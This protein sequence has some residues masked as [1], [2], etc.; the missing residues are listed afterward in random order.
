MGEG[1][2]LLVVKIRGGKE[3]PSKIGAIFTVRSEVCTL[4]RTRNCAPHI[5]LAPVRSC[6]VWPQAYSPFQVYTPG[7]SSSPLPFPSLRHNPHSSHRHCKAP[8]LSQ[9][10]GSSSSQPLSPLSRSPT[11]SLWPGSPSSA[12]L[13]RAGKP[14]VAGTRDEAGM[15][16]RKGSYG[17]RK[18]GGEESGGS[19]RGLLY[20][21]FKTRTSRCSTMRVK[22]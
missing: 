2:F 22:G 20:W 21:L 9:C 3:E 17:R 16:G 11:L 12:S 13:R 5:A 1:G 19:N 15:M 18:G 4:H 8:S 10:P 7:S 14:E 6:Q